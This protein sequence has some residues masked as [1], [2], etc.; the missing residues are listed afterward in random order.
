MTINKSEEES[1]N[2]FEIYLYTREWQAHEKGRSVLSCC[3]GMDEDDTS[4]N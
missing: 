3:C 2:L 1:N 4:L